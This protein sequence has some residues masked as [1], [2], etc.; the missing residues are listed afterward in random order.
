MSTGIAIR[1][2]RFRF[3]T[4]GD[5]Q[6]IAAGLGIFFRDIN[7]RGNIRLDPRGPDRNDE[8]F[9]AAFPDH[10]DDLRRK[11]GMLLRVAA[12]FIRAEVCFG[13]DELIYQISV[14]SM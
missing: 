2:D 12:I 11:S 1:K 10:A 3:D 9:P 7:G 5:L 8:V 4:C 13:G 14:A 6:I